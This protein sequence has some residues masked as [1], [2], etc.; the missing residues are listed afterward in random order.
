M[1][2]FLVHQ[3]PGCVRK[4]TDSPQTLAHVNKSSCLL[5]RAFSFLGCRMKGYKPWKNIHLQLR[6]V[7]LKMAVVTPTVLGLSW[8]KNA[9]DLNRLHGWLGPAIMVVN[10]K[11]YISPMTG[12]Q[13]NSPPSVPCSCIFQLVSSNC[14]EKQG[15]NACQA[16]AWSTRKLVHF[17]F[18]HF[19]PDV[20][21]KFLFSVCAIGQWF[22]VNG[23]H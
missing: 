13:P 12:W 20:M 4:D 9:F 8:S 22:W 17:I 2:G 18:L 5:Q 6:R 23:S 11:L 16:S 14:T 21:Y 19:V 10:G 1:Q 7:N 3:G 15:T